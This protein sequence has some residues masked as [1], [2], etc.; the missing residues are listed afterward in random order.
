MGTLRG[1]NGEGRPSEG[2]GLPDLPPEWG[3]V[4]IPDD[5][6]ELSR[7]AVAIR[8]ELRRFA[9]RNRWRRRLHRP[10]LTESISADT[11]SLGLP[12]L[13]MAIA[14][15]AT[16]TSLFALAWP[17][18][19]VRPAASS[20]PHTTSTPALV[21]DL[22]L[23]NSTGGPVHL[24]NTLPAVL[25]LADGCDCVDL[26]LATARAVP[27]GVTVLAVGRLVPVLPTGIP[28]GLRLIGLADPE[29]ALRSVYAGTPPLDGVIAVLVKGTGEVIRTVHAV[30]RLD[31]FQAD[32]PRLVLP[33][34]K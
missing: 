27:A 20:P 21:P 5:P 2:G 32:L 29:G 26:E 1:D 10:P 16:L 3:T 17:G 34:A 30:T 7:E 9:R 8:R 13:I 25:L 22:T 4:V 6:A 14:I 15:I 23:V 24:R 12:I 33:A 11:P 31:D 18:G 19:T 28:G